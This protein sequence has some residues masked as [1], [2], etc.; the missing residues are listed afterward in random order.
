M[1]HHGDRIAALVDG[2]LDHD[3]RDRLLVHIAQCADCRA[4]VEQ[5]RQLKAMLTQ[6]A[7]PVPSSELLRKL[8]SMSEPGE[9]TPPARRP[10]NPA[11]PWAERERAAV[12]EWTRPHGA[13]S[14]DGVF[15]L[16]RMS[17]HRISIAAAAAVSASALT[18]GLALIG[19][20][21]PQPGPALTPPMD[22]YVQQHAETTGQMFGDPAYP[23]VFGGGFEGVPR[24]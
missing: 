4:A 16:G 6:V 8:I 1:I 10:L 9:P 20:D 22:R 19:G 2:E 17:R 5:Q 18:A 21:P 23:V 24:R 14:S 7:G 12:A 3:T 11:V 13:G 15:G